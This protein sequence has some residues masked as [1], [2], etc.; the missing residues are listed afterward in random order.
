MHNVPDHHRTRL[1]RGIHA[2]FLTPTHTRT[3]G[4]P[5]WRASPN[6][7]ARPAR[8]PLIHRRAPH[9]S[10]CKW[11]PPTSQTTF[12]PSKARHIAA[13]VLG[14]NRCLREAAHGMGAGLRHKRY[15]A[16]SKT[17]YRHFPATHTTTT[18]RHP[19]ITHSQPV[20]AHCFYHTRLSIIRIIT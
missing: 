14:G 17:G 11:P 4:M 12:Q 13:E 19:I 16:H 7:R 18:P 10:H 2:A 6:R 20:L 9:A 1:H 5:M 3:S 8:M 15:I